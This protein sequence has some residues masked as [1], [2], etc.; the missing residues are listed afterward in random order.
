[1]T[2]L[3]GPTSPVL[4]ADREAEAERLRRAQ[5]LAAEEDEAQRLR[6]KFEKSKFIEATETQQSLHALFDDEASQSLIM[7]LQRATPLSG[8]RAPFP[9]RP[10]RAP[11]PPPPPPQRRGGPAA[12]PEPDQGPHP[13]K[14]NDSKR[15]SAVKVVKGMSFVFSAQEDNSNSCFNTMDGGAADSADPAVPAQRTLSRDKPAK[16][17]KEKVNRTA[18]F[19]LLQKKATKPPTSRT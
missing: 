8:P 10:P 13:H 16:S 1:M 9:A 4:K 19:S 15:A 14:S 2:G 17:S 18:L 3:E 5:V 11:S 6:A 12:A 7:G